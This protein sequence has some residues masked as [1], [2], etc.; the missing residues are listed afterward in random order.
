MYNFQKLMGLN[1]TVYTEFTNSKGQV[2]KLVEH[3][4]KGD[5]AEVIAVCEALQMAANTTFFD[6]DDMLA[7]HKEYEP[8]FED[9][10]FYIGDMLTD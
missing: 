2:I 1:P 5:E 8:S 4:L 7:E 10:H 9:G 3:P 6:T